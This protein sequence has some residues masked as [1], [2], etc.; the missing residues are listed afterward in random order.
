[1]YSDITELIKP[2]NLFTPNGDGKNDVLKFNSLDLFKSNKITVFNRWGVIVYQKSGYQNDWGGTYD[3]SL[4]P[5]GIYFY[6][7]E[8]DDAVLKNALT[9]IHN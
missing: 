7:L 8:V 9:L 4:L 5:A 3:G 2:I 6:V 1:V